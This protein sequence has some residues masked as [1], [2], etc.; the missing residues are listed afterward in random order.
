MAH[1]LEHHFPTLDKFHLPL[2]INRWWSYQQA[3]RLWGMKKG[4]LAPL[5]M[6]LMENLWHL[7]IY[8]SDKVFVYISEDNWVIDA[9]RENTYVG[10]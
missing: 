3:F 5:R 8:K 10:R 7:S 9:F 2:P 1:L 4:H 6:L